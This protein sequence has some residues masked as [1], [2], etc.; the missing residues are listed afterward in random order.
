MID[1]L[2]STQLSQT[3]VAFTIEFDNEFERR[4]PHRT[5][6]HGSTPGAPHAPWLVSLVMWSNCM[7]FIGEE[8]V[9]LRDLESLARTPANLKGM[10][11]WG[12]IVI[13]KLSASDLVIHVTAEGRMAQEVWRPLFTIIEKRWQERFGKDAFDRLREALLAV[14]AQI[15]VELPDCLPI[16]GYGLFSK[17]P[18]RK[19]RS[20]AVQNERLPLSALLSRVLLAFALEF[21]GESDLSLAI[22][23]DVVRVLDESGVAARDLPRITGVSK[24]AIATALSFLTKRGFA[25]LETVSRTKVARLTANGRKAQET[26]HQ[27]LAAIEERWPARFGQ[28]TV[29]A[30]RDALEHFAGEPLWRGL[31][32]RPEN[33]RASVPKPQTLP[34]YPMVL[35][36]GGFPDGS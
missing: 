6:N 14:V 36:R 32:P 23:A 16:L 4:M 30:L 31:E 3:V 35:H 25:T 21:E 18:D 12:Y 22:C 2:L 9:R 33:W 28:K 7:R 15:D 5:S 17:G 1:S 26:Y 24:E 19:P 29:Q 8:G 11:R 10:E 13:Q 27:L 20:S 34:H